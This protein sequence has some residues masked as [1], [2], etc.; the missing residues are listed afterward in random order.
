MSQKKKSGSASTLHRSGK[1]MPAVSGGACHQKK[2]ADIEA[3]FDA[4]RR[5]RHADASRKAR[6]AARATEAALT[7]G[8]FKQNGGRWEYRCPDCQQTV[9]LG[10]TVK[11]DVRASSS[12]GTCSTVPPLQEWLRVNGFQS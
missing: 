4:C 10:V 8:G 6:D 9:D 12:G 2:R 5:A 11:G 3:I 1:H 7:L